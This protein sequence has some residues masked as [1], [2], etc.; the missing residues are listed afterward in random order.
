[1]SSFPHTTLTA[2]EL[3]RFWSKILK[4]EGCWLGPQGRIAKVTANSASRQFKELI[5]LTASHG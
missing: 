3:S 4:T 1:M 2:K 5:S